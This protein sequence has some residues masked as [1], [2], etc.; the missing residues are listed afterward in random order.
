MSSRCAALNTG[1]DIHLLDH[2]APLASLL[3]IP[4]LVTEE[5]NLQLAQL[6]YPETEICL[7]PD[8]EFRLKDLAERYDALIECK[9]WQPHLKALFKN[10]YGKEMRLIFCPHG[11]SD[12]GYGVPLLAPYAQQDSVLLYGD[13]M[14]E[15]LRELG[16]WPAISSYTLVGNYRLRYYR[17]RQAYCDRLAEERVFSRLPKNRPTLLY[18]P[19]WRDADQATSFFEHG[20]RIIEDLPSEWNL[21]IKLHPLLEERDPARFYRIAAL[22]ERKSNALLLGDFPSVY[23][24]LARCDAYL[25]DASSV[26]YDFLYFQ[27]PMFFLPAK[28]PARIHACGRIVDPSR[29]YAEF[30]HALSNP[31]GE[32]Q[33]RLYCYAF[34][35]AE[36]GIQIF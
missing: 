35:A 21:L 1:S 4:L 26:G 8:L 11:Q 2:I 30:D 24:L 22:A 3:G 15:M 16:L 9:Y 32:E 31:Y 18:A 23:P 13:L 28:R 12:K 5:K 10:L 25:G 17:Q 29:P 36:E 20:T 27:R 14:I 6:H 7:M 33:A 19:T 34:S